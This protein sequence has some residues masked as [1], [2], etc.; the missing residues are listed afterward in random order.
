MSRI[1]RQ[2]DVRVHEA[3][4]V[5]EKMTIVH[6]ALTDRRGK[7]LLQTEVG[8]TGVTYITNNE[9]TGQAV[10]GITLDDLL[11]VFDFNQVVIKIDVFKHEH[12]VLKGA[13]KFFNQVKVEAVLIE[14]V[15]HQ[16]DDYGNDGAFIVQFFKEHGLEPDLPDDIKWEYKKWK[17]AEIMFKRM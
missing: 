6:N 16:A 3:A 15:H 4:G 9:K 2:A 1:K 17:T 11:E 14:F 7:V 5:G 13:L 12:F 8:N 10:Y